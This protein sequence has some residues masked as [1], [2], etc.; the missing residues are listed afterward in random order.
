MAPKKKALARQDVPRLG[1]VLELKESKHKGMPRLC[2]YV[3]DGT[4]RESLVWLLDSAPVEA[5]VQATDVIESD[6]DEHFS[7]AGRRCR[8]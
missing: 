1:R 2:V 6:L 4:H 3:L 7:G 5:L 8:G